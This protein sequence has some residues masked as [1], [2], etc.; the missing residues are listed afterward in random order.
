MNKR[1][2]SSAWLTI[3]VLLSLPLSAAAADPP[4]SLEPA[5]PS[6]AAVAA[7]SAPGGSVYLVGHHPRFISYLPGLHDQRTI[8]VF[9]SA[10]HWGGLASQQ[11]DVRCSERPFELR[12][13]RVRGTHT[14]Q[15]VLRLLAWEW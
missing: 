6:P 8:D 2:L 5:P 10:Q 1:L 9:Y 14:A 3:A 7:Q 15:D 11:D 13:T 12:R 4:G